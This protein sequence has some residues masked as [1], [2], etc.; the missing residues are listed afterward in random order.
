MSERIQ[1]YYPTRDA[2]RDMQF[3]PQ[4]LHAFSRAYFRYKSADWKDNK[5]FLLKTR[6]AEERA[7]AHYYVMDL[8]KNM[9]ETNGSNCSQPFLV[10]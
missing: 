9:A 1:R 3:A 5:P 10:R 6:T 4:G 7:A 2:N 8:H